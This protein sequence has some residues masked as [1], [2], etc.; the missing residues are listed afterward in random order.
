MLQTVS[1]A[2]FKAQ[3]LEY[4]RNVVAERQPLVV[5][6]AGKP[7]VEI[8]PYMEKEESAL[9]MLRNSVIFYKNPTRPVGKNNWEVLK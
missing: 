4:L 5:T 8:K 6:H 2:Q 9:E 7:V 1:K 3:V